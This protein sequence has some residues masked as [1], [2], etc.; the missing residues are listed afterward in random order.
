MVIMVN[1][2]IYF[3]TI[4]TH[5]TKGRKNSDANRWNKHKARRKLMLIEYI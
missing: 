4:A 2:V 3:N 5:Y 1:I